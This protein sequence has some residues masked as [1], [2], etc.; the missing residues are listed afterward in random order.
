MNELSVAD[1]VALIRW[2]VAYSE[3]LQ[4]AN[5]EL[6][7]T[8]NLGDTFSVESLRPLRDDDPLGQRLITAV[9]SAAE[10][11]KA[12]NNALDA[13]SG[14]LNLLAGDADAVTLYKEQTGSEL[15]RDEVPGMM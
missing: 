7:P 12:T 1:R 14:L 13:L 6:Q 10:V 11:V 5:V 8:S 9:E 15:P 4:R 2:A 3:S